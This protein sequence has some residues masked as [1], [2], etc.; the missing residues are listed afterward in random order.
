MS[1][2]NEQLAKI[3]DDTLKSEGLISPSEKQLVNKIV[4]GQMKDSD[5]KIALEEIINMPGKSKQEGN[6]AE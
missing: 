6:E 1:D 2:T 4:K 5:W 3:I